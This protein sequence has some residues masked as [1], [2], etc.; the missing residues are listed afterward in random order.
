MAYTPWPLPLP[1]SLLT[2]LMLKKPAVCATVNLPLLEVKVTK[3]AVVTF[4]K[5]LSRAEPSAASVR[6]LR[7]LM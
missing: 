3:P 5:P 1:S 4:V 6:F 2:T 7:A